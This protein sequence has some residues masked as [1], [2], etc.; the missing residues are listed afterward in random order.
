M[1]FAEELRLQRNHEYYS[2]LRPW[3]TIFHLEDS[4]SHSQDLRPSSSTI[5]DRA[6]F[7]I[8]KVTTN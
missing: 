7:L 1:F 6:D 3:P 4:R 2:L 8:T 5:D